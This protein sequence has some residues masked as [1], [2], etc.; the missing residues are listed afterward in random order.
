[1]DKYE[2]ETSNRERPPY[3]HEESGGGIFVQSKRESPSKRK[4]N[5]NKE[6]VCNVVT[7]RDACGLLNVVQKTLKR[8]ADRLYRDDR[9][10]YFELDGLY[11]SLGG[12]LQGVYM[13]LKE[14]GSDI[15]NRVY[16]LLRDNG[17][18]SESRKILFEKLGAKLGVLSDEK[19]SSNTGTPKTE[20]TCSE[21]NGTTFIAK[22]DESMG[23]DSGE[24]NY[25]PVPCN[26]LIG[27]N[28]RFRR[29]NYQTRHKN[30]LERKRNGNTGV[31][32]VLIRGET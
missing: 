29:I 32:R 9:N 14:S 30:A 4:I 1:M 25:P 21:S 26:S 7:H 24:N 12:Y 23:N 17:C 3:G 28:L 22:H 10:L 13:F 2:N 11:Y 8:K 6:A 15:E 27:L 5:A 20:K 16:E 18:H 31:Y 19:G